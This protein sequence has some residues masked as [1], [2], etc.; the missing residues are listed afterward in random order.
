MA[1][2]DATLEDRLQ[3]GQDAPLPE[4][5]YAVYVIAIEDTNEAHEALLSGGTN[6]A[7]FVLAWDRLR[8]ALDEVTAIDDVENKT[9]CVD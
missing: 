2:F 4:P 6:V 7:P 9:I 8:N 5:K 1:T 3:P